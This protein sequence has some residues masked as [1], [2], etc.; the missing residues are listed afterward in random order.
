MAVV[1]GIIG[2]GIFRN[3]GEVAARVGTGALV[4]AAWIIGGGVALAGAFCFAELG[5]RRPQA[6]GGYVYLRD[7]FGPLPAF[8]YG[9]TL[10]LVINTG[11]IAWVAMTFATYCAD[12]FG[13]G[14]AAQKPMAVAAIALLSA[15][16]FLGVR[17]GAATQNV[18]TVLKLLALALVIIV[19]LIAPVAAPAAPA[20]GAPAA[21]LTPQAIFAALGAAL[22]PVLFSYGGWQNTNFIAGEI[23]DAQKKLPR[24]LLLGVGIVV[25]VYVLANIAYLRVLGVAGLATSGASA[26]AVMRAGL[27]PIGGSI[28][29]A[30]IMISTF[31]FLSLVILTAPRVY[32]TMAADGLFF[33]SVARVHPRHRTPTVAL[34]LQAV[35]AIGVLLTGSYDELVNYVTFGDWIFFGATAATLFVFRRRDARAGAD[36]ARPSFLSPLYPWPP[37][38]FCLAALY[39]VVS[40]LGTSPKNS[41]LAAGLILLG[42]PVFALWRTRSG[43][44]SGSGSP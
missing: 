6:G 37:L 1:G 24:A 27:G 4:L 17:L 7:A 15:V 8:L 14:P 25:L 28:I 23:R 35:W 10:L 31:G 26:S 41:L 34:L 16:N 9:W 33:A 20:A 38:L 22:I 13:L 43:S 32:Q 11:A 42:I 44:R 29:A 30:G 18:L 36:A 2:A 40:A 19:G 39:V 3:P 21:P 12:L 5:A